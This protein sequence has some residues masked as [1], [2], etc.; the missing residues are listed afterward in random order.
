MRMTII[1][2]NNLN[3]NSEIYDIDK[4]IIDM[5]FLNDDEYLLKRWNHNVDEIVFQG[6]IKNQDSQVLDPFMFEPIVSGEN[7]ITFIEFYIQTNTLN[8]YKKFK[9]NPHKLD[10]KENENLY[11]TIDKMEEKI[12][13]R[14]KK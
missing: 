2:S 1:I 6:F 11:Y 3:N 8:I 4:D 5:R 9:I 14:V 13:F 10:D 12:E 7:G